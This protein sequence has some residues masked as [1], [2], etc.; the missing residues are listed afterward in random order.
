MV[1]RVPDSPDLLLIWNNHTERTNL[2]SAISRD[3]GQTWGNCRLIEEQE[4]WPVSRTHAFPSLAFMNGYAHMTY[5]ERHANPQTGRMFHLIYARR[6]VSWF[7]EPRT[8]RSPLRTA[9]D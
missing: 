8:I 2:T 3:G 4:D 1:R 9:N 6:P 7:Y 5:Y